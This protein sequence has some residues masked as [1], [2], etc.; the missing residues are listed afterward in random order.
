MIRK[1]VLY[2]TAT[3]KSIKS[4]SCNKTHPDKKTSYSS[5][6]KILN[7]PVDIASN[8]SFMFYILF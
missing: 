1:S 3:Y 8:M 4:C 5:T 6:N 7:K 2:F